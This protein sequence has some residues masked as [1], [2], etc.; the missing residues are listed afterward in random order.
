MEVTSRGFRATVLE[1]I[2]IAEN[3]DKTLWIT[4]NVSSTA[5]SCNQH[6]SVSYLPANPPEPHEPA[7]GSEQNAAASRAGRSPRFLVV[8]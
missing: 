3:D 1:S 6:Y 2:K 4:M 7:V 5:D 8:L